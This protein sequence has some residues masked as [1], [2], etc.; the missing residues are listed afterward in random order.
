MKKFLL[1]IIAFIITITGCGGIEMQIKDYYVYTTKSNLKH[2]YPVDVSI[3]ASYKSKNVILKDDIQEI[4]FKELEA[5]KLFRSVASK[6]DSKADVIIEVMISEFKEKKVIGL[7]ADISIKQ[8][9]DKKL[10]YRKKV[11]Q[12][13]TDENFNN[14]ELFSQLLKNCLISFMNDI[15]ARFKQYTNEGNLPKKLSTKKVTCAVFPFMDTI[16]KE[17][18]GVAVASMMVTGLTKSENIKV[19]ERE[20]I[21]KAVKELEF[22]ISGYTDASKNK[23][24]GQILNAD[25]LIYGEITKIKE[26]YQITMRVVEVK[27]GEIVLPRSTQP[28][29]PNQFGTLVAQQANFVAQFISTGE[30]VK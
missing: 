16:E 2:S 4:C 26:T 13:G 8:L 18:Y 20:Q 21:Q 23:E 5:K 17:S 1:F 24:L 15:D 3:E 12:P 14:P 11:Q 9:P 28:S 30:P 6:D 7:M 29:D 22:Q 10:I 19:V 27:Q 25:F